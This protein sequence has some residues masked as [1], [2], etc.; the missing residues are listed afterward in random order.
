MS[1]TVVLQAETYTFVYIDCVATTLISSFLAFL[2][3]IVLK[4]VTAVPQPACLGPSPRLPITGKNCGEASGY[5]QQP[6][7]CT[8]LRPITSWFLHRDHGLCQCP[9]SHL[10]RGCSQEWGISINIPPDSFGSL[11]YCSQVQGPACPR[12][13]IPGQ[14]MT[15]PALQKR[16][17]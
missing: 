3:N 5:I 17:G 8:A 7:E 13:S 11:Q 4:L 15:S 1:W 2:E 9:T 10:G 12:L 6:C 16:V 14:P